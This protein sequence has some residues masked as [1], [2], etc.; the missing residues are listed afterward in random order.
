MTRNC[1]RLVETSVFV[2][3]FVDH[4]Q[5]SDSVTGGLK[6]RINR[7]TLGHECAMID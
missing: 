7:E 2:A 6:S 1:K 5:L 3:I 4:A